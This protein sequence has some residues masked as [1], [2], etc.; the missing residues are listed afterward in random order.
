MAQHEA[1]ADVSNHRAIAD[2]HRR[3]M[4]CDGVLENLSDE[5]ISVGL[6]LKLGVVSDE[7]A[8]ICNACTRR[9]VE[10][11]KLQGQPANRR[12]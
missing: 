7:C 10:A 3:C 5:T 11:R 4:C 2:L 6:D 8:L 12:R 9:L 1:A